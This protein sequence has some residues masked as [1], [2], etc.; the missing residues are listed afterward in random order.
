MLTLPGN[1]S[2]RSLA[3]FLTF[4]ISLVLPIRF[5][6]ADEPDVRKMLPATSA[7]Y[8]EVK[9]LESV[10][11]H[12]LSKTL[13]DSSAL[14]KLWRS[15]DAMKLRG[16]LLLF[17][18]AIGDKVESL[19][20]NLTANGFH[21]VV[22]KTTEGAGF[23]TCTESKEWLDEY[24]QKLVK[25]ARA[26]A[27]SKNQPDP[28]REAEYRGIRGYE[29]Q[30]VIVGS[31]GSI[32][33]V[34]NKKELSKNIIDRHL[35]STDDHL[36]SNSLFQR[37]WTSNEKLELKDSE[38]SIA[39]AF[40]DLDMLRNAGV[41]ADLLI[42]KA[43]D[44]ASELILGGLLASIQKTSFATGELFLAENKL[45]IQLCVPYQREWTEASRTFF[46]GP[47]G[48]G[49]ASSLIDSS[50]WMAS[51]SA[52][53]N[54]T[55]L[56]IR[57]GDLFDEKV[58]DQLAQADSTLTTLFSGKDFGRDILGAIEPQV[59]LVAAE[60]QF[61]PS[62]TPAI[63]LPSF[64]LVAK[65][66]DPRMK[67]E[68]KRIFQSF[69][70]FL[71]VA[72]AMEGNPQ[73]DLDSESIDGKQIYTAAYIREGDKQYENGLPIQFNFSPTL[74]FDGDLVFIASTNT[75][76][77]KVAIL[78]AKQNEAEALAKN[79]P[80]LKVDFKSAQNALE[81]NR[82]Q[83]VAQNMLEKGHSKLEAEKETDTLISLLSLLRTGTA[84]L[85]FDDHVRLQFDL[86][87]NSDR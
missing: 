30:N 47:M 11:E 38:E 80:V 69:I 84:A 14:K 44:F 81:T 7:I 35:D 86:D 68:L 46:V 57:A 50:G 4:L 43:R 34:T 49:H 29:F 61:E 77:K 58:N 63:Q 6:A 28:I 85:R 78:S 51:L 21:F 26:D 40:V 27:N 24:L 54:L 9:S 37:A 31:I 5:T 79:N 17:E 12:P 76:V 10:L 25:L 70:G 15:P 87:I 41:A 16:G 65:L 45:S 56:W 3:A 36:L 20:K 66:K 8:I 48:N 67:K 23:L 42:G 62:N 19:A 52:Y 60:Q 72:G 71:N 83:W 55:E 13:Q 33:L 2:M 64:G 1:H 74:A 75:L 18:F 53:R 73:L 59:Q 39:K 82:R 22:D 32:L